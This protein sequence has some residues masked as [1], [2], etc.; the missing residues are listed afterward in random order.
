MKSSSIAPAVR[1]I[2][3]AL[4]FGVSQ[5]WAASASADS[6]F[7]RKLHDKFPNTEGAVVAPA[8]AGFWSIVK[9]GQVVYVKD[10]MSLL[11]T[12]DVVD[13][14]RQQSISGELLAKQAVKVSQADIPL[15]NAI[16]V[17]TGAHKLIVF[18]DPDCP[19]CKAL[20]A[21]LGQVKGAQIYVLPYPVVQLHPQAGV[22]A[23]AIWCEPDRAGAWKAYL[24]SGR[25][26]SGN[27]NC[28]NPVEANVALGNR[29][30]IHATPTL[31]FEDGTLVQGA[32]SA[33]RIEAQLI[34]S[35]KK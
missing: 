31:V 17:A 18:S 21:E 1:A 20:E 11:I 27:G 3:L 26:P 33:A 6:A 23:K 5:S 4:T 8:F 22:V 10:D 9:D 2:A 15:Q 30:R 14:K 13:L 19:H 7:L 12:G 29:L 16:Q 32:I 28:V 24:L 35:A 25:A 34:A